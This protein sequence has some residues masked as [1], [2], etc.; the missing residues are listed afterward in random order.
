M[1]RE[2]TE[3]RLDSGQDPDQWIQN[4]ELV[5]RRLQILGNTMSDMDLMIRILHNLPNEYSG[6]AGKH[7][8]LSQGEAED[9]V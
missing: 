2:F 4:L 9:Q 8:R 1:K 5:I 6:F 3:S 7:S